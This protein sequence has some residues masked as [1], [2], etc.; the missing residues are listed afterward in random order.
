ME[1]LQTAGPPGSWMGPVPTELGT[2]RGQRERLGDAGSAPWRCP[3]LR[4]AVSRT[5]VFGLL[6][7]FDVPVVAFGREPAR[8]HASRPAT[9]LLE[10]EEGAELWG[11]L[12]RVVTREAE[13]G[14]LA[15]PVVVSD[16]YLLSLR[17][18]SGPAGPLT[19]VVIRPAPPRRLS[20]PPPELGLTPREVEVARHIARGLGA[21]QI[22]AA[23]GISEHT[24][25]RHTERV[26]VKLGV[27][28]R[29][30]MVAAGRG[31]LRSDER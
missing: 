16:P 11:H 15:R 31:W 25:R 10:A 28:S 14:T 2:G 18:A 22:A 29:A 8:A 3:I 6:E 30:A 24:V 13:A 23:L 5:P 19:L 12:L 1:T 4:L 21:K 9:A 20:S 17:T 26:Y 27:H 7:S